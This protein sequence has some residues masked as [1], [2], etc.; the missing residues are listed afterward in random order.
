MELI[1]STQASDKIKEVIGPDLLLCY[2]DFNKPFHRYTD[3]SDHQLGAVMM[4][5]EKPLAIYSSKLNINQE[6][7][8]IYYLPESDSTLSDLR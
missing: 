4:K 5:N 7:Y 8:M 1:P 6:R 3:A 2:S